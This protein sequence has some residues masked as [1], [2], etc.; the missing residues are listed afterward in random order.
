LR[1]EEILP[2][3]LKWLSFPSLV[4]FTLW[5]SPLYISFQ[6]LKSKGKIVA[7]QSIA[8]EIVDHL[9]WHEPFLEKVK[10]FLSCGH[11]YSSSL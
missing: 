7:P 9:Q 3:Y 4:L 10:L 2:H 5:F 6:I 11:T 8:R 1:D